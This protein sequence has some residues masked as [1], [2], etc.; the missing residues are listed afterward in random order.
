M[1]FLLAAAGGATVLAY[2]RARRLQ[3]KAEAAEALAPAS[4]SPE[5]VSAIPPNRSFRLAPPGQEPPAASPASGSESADA[6]DFRAAL[7]DFSTVASIRV[8][9]PAPRPAVAVASAHAAV[10]RAVEPAR[11]FSLRFSPLLRVGGSSLVVYTRGYEDALAGSPLPRIVPAM[12]Y[13]DIKKP[14]YEPLRDI[15]AD[16]FVPNLNLIPPNTISLMVQNQPFIEA[17]MVGLNHEFGARAPVA[18]VSDRPARKLLPAVLG[19]L[20]RREHGGIAPRRSWP[21]RSATSRRI[22]EWS[23]GSQLGEHNNRDHSGPEAPTQIPTTEAS[24]WSSAA[25][26]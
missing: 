2:R 1:K 19:R 12:A 20:Q 8:P 22:H 16:F 21:R 23:A 3:Q 9:P 17:Y 5:A 25:I 6:R 18:R 13:P 10:M 14:M 7:S 24:S 11:A 15:S 26:C 4:L